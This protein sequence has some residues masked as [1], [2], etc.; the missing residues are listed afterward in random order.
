MW[1]DTR[2]MST[3]PVPVTPGSP[4]AV[5]TP[6]V[7]S[8]PD[9]VVVVRK[10]IWLPVMLA[11]LG[12]VAAYLITGGRQYQAQALLKLGAQNIDQQILGLAQEGATNSN[13]IIAETVA[14]IDQL[15]TARA[16]RGLLAGSPNMT[17]TEIDEAV[18]VSVDTK[19]FLIS[20]AAKD[21]S[22]F[23]A[24][25]LANYYVQA[26]IDIVETRDL[27]RLNEIEGQ[28]R[29]RLAELRRT[30]T[31]TLNGL[32]AEQKDLV[33]RTLAIQPAA[34]TAQVRQKLEQLA[35][36]KRLKTQSVSFARKA[37]I[38][39]GP[40]G[41]PPLLFIIAGA[42]AGGVIGTALAFLIAGRDPKVRAEE[43][44]EGMLTAPILVRAP[45]S[46][47]Q[48]ERKTTPFSALRPI[49]AESARVA[50]A[51]LRLNPASRDARAIAVVSA[52]DDTSG[53][54]VALQIAG[55][56]ARTPFTVL[57]INIGSEPNWDQVD[58]LLGG[59]PDGAGAL[60]EEDGGDGTLHRLTLNEQEL[61]D[62]RVA[63][64]RSWA[65]QRYDRLVIAS[66]TPDR[67]AAGVVMMRA[68][69]TAVAVVSSGKTARG[70]LTRLRDLASQIGVPIAGTFA[71]GFGGAE[72]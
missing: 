27:N 19:T 25:K 46:I 66:P 69:D 34:E 65:L 72:D 58:R 54:P 62:D 3:V 14:N 17:P 33:R 6:A 47:A 42:F 48:D 71:T 56:L 61:R 31:E 16:A 18:D 70:S 49:E 9:T 59:A 12:A 10:L 24:A 26:Y 45:A 50:A 68:A 32:S 21:K 44:V 41:L 64:L 39:T 23:I 30:E 20:V 51:Q 29:K 5:A 63:A 55:A 35:V 37:D 15:D 43:T 52:D 28:L 36:L 57:L 11:I 53:D 2:F 4:P 22:P 67:H 13:L 60:E 38:P 1:H 8:A 40:S 7:S